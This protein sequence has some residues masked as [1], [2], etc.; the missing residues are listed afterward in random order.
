M[1]RNM[2]EKVLCFLNVVEI[3]YT[4]ILYFNNEI[5]SSHPDKA[6]PQLL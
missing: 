3:K 5:Q 6:K 1:S 2:V 4:N